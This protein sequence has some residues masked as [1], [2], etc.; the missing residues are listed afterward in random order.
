MQQPD[1]AVQYE[2]NARL[3]AATPDMLDAL[4]FVTGAS[5]LCRRQCLKPSKMQS[6]KLWGEKPMKITAIKTSNFLGARDVDI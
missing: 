1:R 6:Q 5:R 4:Q 2:N 3:I